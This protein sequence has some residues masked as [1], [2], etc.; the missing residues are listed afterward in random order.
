MFIY[1]YSYVLIAAMFITLNGKFTDN[2]NLLSTMSFLF[3]NYS[4]AKAISVD[5]M[6]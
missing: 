1:I 4:L 3:K 5:W 6:L 2:K